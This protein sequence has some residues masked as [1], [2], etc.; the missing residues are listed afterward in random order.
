LQYPAQNTNGIIHRG[1]NTIQNSTMV[2]LAIF[3]SSLLFRFTS[4]SKSLEELNR[5]RVIY[6]PPINISITKVIYAS[7]NSDKI[8]CSNIF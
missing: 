6:A 1:M 2:N 4:L 5:M 7:I 3:I 8:I